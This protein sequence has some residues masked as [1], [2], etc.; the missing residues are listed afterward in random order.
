M[1]GLLL[2]SLSVT[3]SPVQA[4]HSWT[5][6]TSEEW[7]PLYCNWDDGAIGFACS[8]RYCDN[9]NLA[10]AHVPWWTSLDYNTTY[11]S[12]YFSEEGATGLEEKVFVDTLTGGYTESL[13]VGK[14]FHYC[15]G[16][17]GPNKGIVTGMQCKGS[18]CD[19][20]SLECTK[21]IGGR[22]TGCWWSAWLSE[23]Q[24]AYNFGEGNFIT[25]VECR[26]SYCD[27]KRFRVCSLVE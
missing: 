5:G 15:F 12:P 14:N 27:N 20:I 6:S 2:I 8:G 3:V 16:G 4:S 7:G 17:L 21:P 13:L 25:A 19:N 26:G 1:E 18:Y 10:C 22:L 24:G 9:V 11:W 23:E